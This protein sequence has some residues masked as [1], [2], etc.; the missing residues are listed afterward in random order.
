MKFILIL[1]LLL[2]TLAIAQ[3]KQISQ[4]EKKALKK[5]MEDEKKYAKEQKFY[6]GSEYDLKSKEVDPE[7]LKHIKVIEPEND[8]DMD[9]VYN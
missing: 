7:S 4:K 9:D 2:G 6:T 1:S 5:A 3:D 8:F